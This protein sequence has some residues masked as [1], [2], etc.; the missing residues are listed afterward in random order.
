MTEL[1][2]KWR[3]K[4]ADQIDEDYLKAIID[5]HEDMIGVLKDGAESKDTEISALANKLLPSVQDHLARAK[6]LKK[7]VD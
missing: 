4:K 2:K 7:T 3:E 1:E 5:D 6:E